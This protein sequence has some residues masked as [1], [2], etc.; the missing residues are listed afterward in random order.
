M[1]SGKVIVAIN[2]NNSSKN[3][4][5]TFMAIDSEEN[6]LAINV[7]NLALGKGPIIGDTVA[8]GDPLFKLIEIYDEKESSSEPVI[9]YMSLR[10]DNPLDLIVRGQ[11]LNVS[12]LARPQI[13]NQLRRD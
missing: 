9:Q 10:V 3:V 5:H 4:N 12:H 6:C 8:I 2:A 13:D 1:F 7:Y 11:R